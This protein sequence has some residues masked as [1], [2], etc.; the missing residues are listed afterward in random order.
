MN[1]LTIIQAIEALAAIVSDAADLVQT[2][3]AVLSETDT[4]AIH[5][6]LLKAEAAT[7]AM[8]PQVDAALAAAA[9]R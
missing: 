2:G 3:R 1:P 8:R 5:A 7:A 4:Q 9:Q 6:A